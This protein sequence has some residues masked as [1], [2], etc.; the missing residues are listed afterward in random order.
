M[1]VVLAVSMGVV[2][3]DMAAPLVPIVPLPLVKVAEVE[4]KTVPAVCVI[5]P[6]PLA[7]IVSTVPDTLAPRTMPPLVPVA[8][9]DSAPL[10]VTVCDTVML[11][12]PPAVSVRL[13][14]APVEAAPTVTALESVR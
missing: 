13:N 14:I 8:S 7:V 1:P 11:P 12:A 5:V 6:E 3:N 9:K 4:P 10:A 2:D